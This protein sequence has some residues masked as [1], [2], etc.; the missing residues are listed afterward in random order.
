MVLE[1]ADDSFNKPLLLLSDPISCIP[2]RGIV[3]VKKEVDEDP[4]LVHG[5][6][7]FFPLTE[8]TFIESLLWVGI[9]KRILC[10]ITAA[11]RTDNL[12][13]I[14]AGITAMRAND[15]HVNTVAAISHELFNKR[16][17]I[18]RSSAIGIASSA[19]E[20]VFRITRTTDEEVRFS[21][22][23]QPCGVFGINDDL[24]GQRF[25]GRKN[26]GTFTS[27]GKNENDRRNTSRPL[28]CGATKLGGITQCST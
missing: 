14:I 22:T 27:C 2:D 15:L 24:P 12:P 16:H 19:V 7:P 5:G 28:R 23:F 26:R 9:N 11:M 20:E 21:L 4:M 13:R 1:P 6:E 10:R 8:D 3:V 25:G 18:T 17:L